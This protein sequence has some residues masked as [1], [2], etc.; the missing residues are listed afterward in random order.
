MA[1]NT[2]MQ[3][4]YIPQYAH[5]QTTAVSV[6]VYFNMDT[7]F[8]VKKRIFIVTV[9]KNLGLGSLT[10]SSRKMVHN[11]RW[12]HLEIIPHIHTNKPSSAEVTFG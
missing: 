8:C 11:H 6:E 12:T 2:A 3:G 7:V 5:M 4:T 10:L 1:T 9:K